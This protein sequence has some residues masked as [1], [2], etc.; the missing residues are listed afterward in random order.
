MSLQIEKLEHNMAK[1]T[2]TVAADV[3]KK[4]TTQAYNKQKNQFNIPGFRKG[5]VPQ[6][7]IEKMYGPEIFY[8]EAAN[9]CMGPAYEAELKDSD[10]EIVSRPEIDIVQIEKGKDFIFTCEVALKPEVTLGQYKGLDGA[11]EVEEV[12][13]EEVAAE[14]VKE[15]KA[16]AREISIEDRAIEEGD[17]VNIDF[18]GSIDGVAFDGGTAEGFDLVIGSHSFIDT[19]E[20]QLIGKNIGEEVAVNVTF[21]EDY[22][23]SDLAGQPALFEVKINA[24][25]KEELP[26]IDD[27]FA[28]EV[29]EFETL[30]EFKA[31]LKE[32]LA[33]Q[34]EMAAKTDRENKV[35]DAACANAEIDIP[36]AMIEA[37]AE[38]MVN[39]FEQQIVQQFGMRMDQYLEMTG[40]TVEAMV[41]EMK[42]QAV[43]RIQSRLVLEA[44]VKAENIEVSDEELDA[45]FEKMAEMYQMEV[46]QIKSILGTEDQKAAMK[47][48]IAV[49]KAVD[50]I[51]AESVQ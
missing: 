39:E 30:D 51:V 22:Q 25:K 49:Q 3:F 38:T 1:L 7:Y 42:P 24:I 48:D 6:M 50:F 31:S 34:K 36:E 35:V 18:A 2:I 27:E 8:E 9:I 26:V 17:K 28:E 10:L 41:E 46:E 12:T 33:G 47:A 21:P 20:D 29:S 13:D 44:I 43:K 40:N 32:K 45:E 5:K 37:E 16:N 4:A 19:F 11:V 23:V 15:Q 14:L